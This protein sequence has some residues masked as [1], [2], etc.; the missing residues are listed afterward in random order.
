MGLRVF[1]CVL[2]TSLPVAGFAQQGAVPGAPGAEPVLQP[3]PPKAD[4]AEGRIRLDVVVTEKKGGPVAGLERR[5]FTILDERKTQEIVSFQETEGRGASAQGLE[6]ILVLDLVNSSFEQASAARVQIGKFLARNGGR[7]DYPTSMMVLSEEGLHIQPRPSTDGSALAAVLERESAAG[8]S[9]GLGEVG[10]FQLS[11]RALASIAEN[12]VKSKA[13]K[14]L[15]WTGPGWPMLA[16]ASF[17][18]S[19]QDRQRTFDTIVEI[20]NRL[21]EARIALYSIPLPG[22]PKTGAPSLV[23]QP[24]GGMM[25]AS[26]A[27]GQ[28]G[29]GP[30]MSDTAEAPSYKAFLRGVKSARQAEMGDLALQVFAVQ[31]GGRVL[32][33][34]NDLAGQI[35]SCV[36]DLSAF[37]TL[38]FTPADAGHPGD[39]HELKVQVGRPGVVVRSSV[40]YYSQ[41]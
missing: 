3:R 26:E 37:Y 38:S 35:A 25:P 16:G 33:P 24:H 1:I 31:S 39:Y 5:E 30:V 21:R 14:I 17:G 40:G 18:S 22:S 8:H 28:S 36:D 11:V 20:S 34:S 32:D 23:S 6:V 9:A 19:S 10:R 4:D 29:S 41:P 15:I 12:E 13:R 2:L 27:P 7:L